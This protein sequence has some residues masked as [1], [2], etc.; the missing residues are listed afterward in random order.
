MVLPFWLAEPVAQSGIARFAKDPGKILSG[1]KKRC[2]AM[3][4]VLKFVNIALR[5]D[6][7]ASGDAYF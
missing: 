5:S 1:G 2:C 7:H 6:W 4:N 3:L